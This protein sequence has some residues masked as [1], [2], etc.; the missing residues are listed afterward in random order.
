[1]RSFA[2]SSPLAGVCD[3]VGA[4]GATGVNV[5]GVS[6]DKDCDTNWPEG[7]FGEPLARLDAVAVGSRTGAAGQLGF[8]MATGV[9]EA[10]PS[11]A[12]LDRRL[13]A[14]DRVPVRKRGQEVQI[15]RSLDERPASLPTLEA[16]VIKPADL[17]LASGQIGTQAVDRDGC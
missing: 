12:S 11:S 13:G 4:G 2:R 17:H 1:M 16:V 3:F 14:G 10:L 15:E 9:L 7:W 8:T 6:V 5:Q